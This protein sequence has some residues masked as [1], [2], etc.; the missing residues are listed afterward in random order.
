MKKMRE[1]NPEYDI[2]SDQKLGLIEMCEWMKKNLH[3]KSWKMVEIGTYVGESADIFS[4]YFKEV[5]TVDPW[6]EIHMKA[7]SCEKTL[8]REDLERAFKENTAG[9]KNIRFIQQPSV[10]ASLLFQDRSLD[11]VYIDGWHRV[12]PAVL[13]IIS[14]L[15]KIKG[16]RWIGGHDYRTEHYCEVIPAV[17]YTLSA[18]DM[19]FPDSSWIKKL[20][21][22]KGSWIRS[23]K[24]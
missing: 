2:G 14:W 10:L 11:F 8:K 16:G 13:D 4:H 20:P 15:P 6:E 5:I 17:R 22:G 19:I 1:R 23:K 18:P 24:A 9:R 3:C 12:F 7:I 21:G